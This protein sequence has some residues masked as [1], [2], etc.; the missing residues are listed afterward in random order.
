MCDPGED[1]QNCSSDYCMKSNTVCDWN[2]ANGTCVRDGCGSQSCCNSFHNK[3]IVYVL[4]SLSTLV[5]YV[6]INQFSILSFGL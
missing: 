4:F 1:E 5:M 6:N 2:L 3:L